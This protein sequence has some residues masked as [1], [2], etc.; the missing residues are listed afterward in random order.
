MSCNLSISHIYLSVTLQ[1]C[2]C[3]NNFPLEH[4]NLLKFVPVSEVT[5]LKLLVDDRNN[6]KIISK[7]NPTMEEK[8]L[9]G[10]FRY[11]SQ[12]MQH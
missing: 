4:V 3:Y 7:K 2:T 5:K 9:S 1:K 12:D 10:L 11:Y 8:K 6:F